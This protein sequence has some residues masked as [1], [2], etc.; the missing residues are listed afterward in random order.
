LNRLFR[1]NKL[2]LVWSVIYSSLSGESFK[3]LRLFVLNMES[4][5]FKNRKKI[6]SFLVENSGSSGSWIEKKPKITK[7]N[8]LQRHQTLQSNSRYGSIT[9]IWTTSR[10]SWQNLTKKFVRSFKVNPGLSDNDH[11]KKYKTSR[12]N[13]QN[14]RNFDYFIPCDSS[15]D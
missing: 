8:C 11:A 2:Y 12:A 3:F 9:R 6:L 15:K 5:E 4:K 13:V 10:S 7:D 14:L 1:F